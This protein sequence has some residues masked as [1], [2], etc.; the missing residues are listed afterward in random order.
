LPESQLRLK[1]DSFESKVDFGDHF[2]QGIWHL[3]LNAVFMRWWCPRRVRPFALRLFGATVG[4][5]CVIRDG[6]YIHFPWK[7]V[8]GDHVWIG[9]DVSVYNHTTV[10]LGDNVCVSQQATLCSSSHDHKQSN[11]PYAHREV[12]VGES[13]WIG[14]RAILLPGVELP[15]GSLVPGGKSLRP[16]RRD[17]S[18]VT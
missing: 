5:G 12:H 14:I 6:V 1:L 2:R 13:S 8:V 7:L 17:A 16:Q 10:T 11:F 18:A 9:R 3:F 4:E 15:A